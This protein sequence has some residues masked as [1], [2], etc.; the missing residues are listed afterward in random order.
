[1]AGPISNDRNEDTLSAA[2]LMM[3][4]HIQ[5]QPLTTDST[6]NGRVS[7]ATWTFLTN[8]AHVLLCIARNPGARLRDVASE[9]GITERAAQRI[10][11]DLVTE[12]YLTRERVGRR[13][14]YVVHDNQPLRH[15]VEQK[16]QVSSLIKLLSL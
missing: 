2:T 14:Q 1:M 3:P 11:A 16:S 10:V 8:H 13:N 9:V 7:E 4:R 5:E 15:P 12:G 6:E